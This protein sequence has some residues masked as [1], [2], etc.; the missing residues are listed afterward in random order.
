[1]GVEKLLLRKSFNF[2]KTNL[3]QENKF[4]NFLWKSTRMVMELWA[5][6]NLLNFLLKRKWA[7]NDN[8]QFCFIWFSCITISKFILLFTIIIIHPDVWKGW[9]EKGG[10]KWLKW[11]KWLIIE[12]IIL[13]KWEK[14]RKQ[15]CGVIDKSSA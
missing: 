13:R 11:I 9:Y 1:M 6:L 3:H 12:F 15:W 14:I 4:E 5:K 8:L 7:R 2:Y 10:E